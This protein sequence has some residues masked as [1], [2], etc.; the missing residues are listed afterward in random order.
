MWVICRA[1]DHKFVSKPGSERSYTYK[2][3]DARVW[4]NHESAAR[5]RCEDEYA[6][7][8]A[9]LLGGNF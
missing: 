5:E 3:Q 1:K 9:A 8:V 7:S 2:L 4:S 6:V